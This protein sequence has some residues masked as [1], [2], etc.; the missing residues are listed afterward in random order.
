MLVCLMVGL[1]MG[2]SDIA[3]LGL[4]L[5]VAAAS[6]W[7]TPIQS[8]RRLPGASGHRAR[9]TFRIL[10]HPPASDDGG[11]T[12]RI[13]SEGPT[14]AALIMAAA[15]GRPPVSALVLVGGACSVAVPVPRSGRARV[16]TAAASVLSFDGV[17][18]QLPAELDPVQVT[19]LPRVGELRRLPLPYRLQGHTGEHVSRHSGD[20][21]ELRS[22]DAFRPGDQLRRIDWRTTARQSADQDRLF[23][24]RSYARSE[25]GIQL[26][27]D[28]A[29]DYPAPVGTWFRPGNVA[30]SHESSL[31]LAREA[32]TLLAASYLAAGDR[33][34]LNELSGRHRPLRA[35]G[36]RRQLELI[37]ATLA[38]MTARSGQEPPA[39]RA[40]VPPGALVY[41]ISSFTDEEPAR[42]MRAFRA[43]GHRVIGVD[44]FPVLQGRAASSSGRRAVRLLLLQRHQ[45]LT[46]LAADLVTVLGYRGQPAPAQDDGLGLVLDQLPLD[47][48]LATLHRPQ[49]SGPHRSGGQ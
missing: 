42:L 37:R 6:G 26:L 20:S 3:V 41:V 9:V 38:L 32:A 28:T 47:V 43:S 49:R 40:G 33:V 7:S 29:S 44:T 16:L 19:V 27:V 14:G 35:A 8:R 10:P 21:G 23:V 18:Q 12:F 2:R 4:P 13:Q 39:R 46:G 48:G 45:V 30:V 22:I 11:R 15:P 17:M 34:G 25:A 36:G 1:F 24:R 5:A 31:H